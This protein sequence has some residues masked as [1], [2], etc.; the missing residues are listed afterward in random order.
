MATGFV[1]S[2]SQSVIDELNGGDF[3]AAGGV[4]EDMEFDTSAT[5]EQDLETGG[6]VELEGNY[7]FEV[8]KV[9]FHLNTIITDE[10][11]GQ[12]KENTPHILVCLTVL[13]SAAKQSPAG[14]V[15][16]HRLY[17]GQKDGSPP[18]KGS[19][20]SMERFAIGM[21]IMRYANIDGRSVPVDA[22]SGKPKLRISRFADILG[23]QCCATCKTEKS[24]DPKYKDQ[25]K[26]PMSRVFAPDHPDVG[27][28]PRNLTAM[29]EAG[30]RVADSAAAK[31]GTATAT[32]ATTAAKS[33]ETSG[34]SATSGN[35]GG[36]TTAK[37]SPA[38]SSGRQ[39]DE[40][41][42]TQDQTQ[43]Q[44]SGGSNWDMSDF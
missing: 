2:E 38:A 40:Q 13:Q 23:R 34:G 42:Q 36:S 22:E 7:H 21:G 35:A 14:S 25:V 18:K 41:T 28:F 16:I 26:I 39:A 11:S 19:I 8:T 12:P 6:L 29:K 43:E 27:H 30:Y 32:T 4:P 15:L 33:L 20:E 10:Q 3:P 1:D 9:E 31:A 5:T 44:S 24:R 37:A 17:C